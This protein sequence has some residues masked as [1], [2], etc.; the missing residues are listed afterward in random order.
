MS[1][2]SLPRARNSQNGMV[3][4]KEAVE[5]QRLACQLDYLTRACTS[6]ARGY[7]R[8]IRVLCREFNSKQ[9][10]LLEDDLMQIRFND[11]LPN[12]IREEIITTAERKFLG[13]RES[14]GCSIPSFRSTTPR[15][16]KCM[17]LEFKFSHVSDRIHLT[18]PAPRS[19]IFIYIVL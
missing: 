10:E 7:D 15:S 18:S 2:S 9:K 6:T 5:R 3:E 4:A 12:E 11:R 13:K 8:E 16:S 14:P 17:Y 19:D 1:V